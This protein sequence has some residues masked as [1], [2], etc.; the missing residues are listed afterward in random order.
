MLL[1]LH[2]PRLRA[3]FHA[4]ALLPSPTAVKSHKP[5]QRWQVEF[6]MWLAT[7]PELPT[8]AAQREIAEQFKVRAYGDTYPDDLREGLPR[9]TFYNLLQRPDFQGVVRKFAE[10]NVEAARAQLM[11]D[12]PEYVAMHM[13]G[14][15]E[16][17]AKK[18]IKTLVSYTSPALD[19][20]MPRKAETAVQATAVTI[21]ISPAALQAP[22]A[23]V[24]AEIIEI[25]AVVEADDDT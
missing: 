5:L 6:A 1:R 23:S 18:D 17:K 24:E 10:G 25:A 8:R 14:A 2:K 3:S 20:V 7:C 22:T 16:A 11:A 12:L 21:N 19:R 4:M 13:W 9:R 15:Q